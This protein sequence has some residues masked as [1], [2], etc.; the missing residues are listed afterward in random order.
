VDSCG[1]ETLEWN[2]WHD[3]LPREDEVQLNFTLIYRG[4]LPAASGGN[5]RVKEK[6]ALRKVFHEQLKELWR[7]QPTLSKMATANV[8]EPGAPLGKYVTF[9]EATA[10]KYARCGLRFIPV[11]SPEQ[12]LSCAVDILFCVVTIRGISSGLAEI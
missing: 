10:N 2:F 6:H 4:E 8:S 9:L 3:D 12:S 7:V 5:S 11:V 1:R